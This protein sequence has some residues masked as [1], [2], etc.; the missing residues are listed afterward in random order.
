MRRR[1]KRRMHPAAPACAV[2]AQFGVSNQLH[3]AAERRRRRHVLLGNRADA[4]RRNGRL[5]G[6][7]RAEAR[8]GQNRQLAA[9]IPALHV[10]RRIGL[11]IA[12][13]LRLAQ[14]RRK[15]HAQIAHLSEQIVGRAVHNAVHARKPVALQAAHDG[16]Q[17]RNT[18][19]HARLVEI[20][21]MM[22]RRQ[23]RQLVAARRH[24]LLVRG[25]HMTARFQRAPRKLIRHAIAADRLHDNL[26]ALVG[27]YILK[28]VGQLHALGH[29]Q[30]A[31][32]QHIHRPHVLPRHAAHRIVIL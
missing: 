32:V 3:C 20:G 10:G 9:R 12:Q 28:I 23:L 29:V 21:H 27:Q 4:L 6:K 16:M 14:R 1:H 25:H 30:L 26:H 22:L 7:F 15:G 17:H 8:V 18:A 24:K 5:V 11:D 19:A 13:P 31:N 2:L